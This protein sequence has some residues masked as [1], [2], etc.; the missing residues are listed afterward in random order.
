MRCPERTPPA[1]V[2]AAVTVAVALGTAWISSAQDAASE[3]VLSIGGSVTEIVHALGEGDPLV[4]R[5][6]TST[7]PPEAE[8]LPDVG[9]M[10]ALSPKGVLSVAPTW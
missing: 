5:D 1:W 4:A 2:M 7:H 10:R 3:R 6:T 9:C 8:D